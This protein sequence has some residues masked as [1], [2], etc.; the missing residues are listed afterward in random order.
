[1]YVDLQIE[2]VAVLTESAKK[3]E[4]KKFKLNVEFTIFRL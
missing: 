1:M 4:P 2:L 3:F